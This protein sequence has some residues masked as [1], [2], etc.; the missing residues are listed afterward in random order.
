MYNS[1]TID[2]KIDPKQARV[3]RVEAA[4]PRRPVIDLNIFVI[5]K[6]IEHH[7]GS[8]A[9]CKKLRSGELLVHVNSAA[10]ANAIMKMKTIHDVPVRV[11]AP[12]FS[13]VRKGVVYHYEFKNMTEDEIVD[14]MHDQAVVAAQHF[15]KLDKTKNQRFNTGMV[16]LTFAGITLPERVVVGW[17]SV[18]VRA[19]VPRPRRCFKCQQYGHASTSCRSAEV[20]SKCAQAGHNAD[21]CNSTTFKCVACNGSHPSFDKDCPS[22][23]RECDI[24][25]V[26]VEAN[27]SYKEAKERVEGP[28]KATPTPGLMYS[29]VLKNRPTMA[30]KGCNAGKP[31]DIIEGKVI[32]PTIDK[33]LATIN[34]N[35]ISQTPLVNQVTTNTNEIPQTSLAETHEIADSSDDSVETAG[36]SIVTTPQHTNMSPPDSTYSKVTAEGPCPQQAQKHDT[37]NMTI[38]QKQPQ[39]IPV[40]K[41]PIMQGD[42][43]SIF[44]METSSPRGRQRSPSSS[45]GTSHES[46]RNKRNKKKKGNNSKSHS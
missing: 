16:T 42:D 30:S 26:K 32:I 34:T 18:D 27:L 7:C 31:E 37:L 9:M 23:K 14:C 8:I 17:E 10:S 29:S 40:T 3:F 46:R 35:E 22:W 12:I 2:L 28:F 36:E 39:T 19:F 44:G 43:D 11:Y 25:K 20:C 45:P 5:R 13:N 15:R 4:D 6:V 21:D 1:Q 38:L 41:Q 24:L 33:N